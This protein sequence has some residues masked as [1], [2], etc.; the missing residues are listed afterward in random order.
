VLITGTSDK[1]RHFHP[2]GVAVCS[3]ETEADFA[4]IFR[5]LEEKTG[6]LAHKVLVADGVEAITNAFLQVFGENFGRVYCWFHGKKKLREK[7]QSAV[8]DPKTRSELYDDISCLQLATTKAE[9]DCATKLFLKKWGTVSDGVTRFV[10]YLHQ[11]CIL[12]R[13]G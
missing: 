6:N 11:E 10:C 2:F 8:K 7:M 9:F 13:N 3:I 12:K 4:F 5:T 1:D